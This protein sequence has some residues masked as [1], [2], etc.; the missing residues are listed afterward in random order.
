MSVSF[1][2]A[3]SSRGGRTFVLWVRGVLDPATARTVVSR[4]TQADR[5]AR[6]SVVLDMTRVTAVE[7]LGLRE[8]TEVTRS[9]A[10]ISRVKVVA[11]PPEV[12]EM[13][14]KAALEEIEVVPPRTRQDRRKRQV[15][16]AVDRRKGTDRRQLAADGSPA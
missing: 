6:T 7:P 13:F 12:A 2:I 8:L 14:R 5:D 1:S 16:V 9:V 3:D 10:G 11:P 4:L 15:P